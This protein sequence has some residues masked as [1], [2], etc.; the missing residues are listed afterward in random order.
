MRPV[1]GITG[2]INI[3]LKKGDDVLAVGDSVEDLVALAE[4]CGFGLGLGSLYADNAFLALVDGDADN[5]DR[6]D[7]HFK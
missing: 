4:D 3:D 2:V 5:G 1:T 7:G 6:G